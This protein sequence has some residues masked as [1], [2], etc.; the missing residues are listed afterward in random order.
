[1]PHRRTPFNAACFTGCL[2]FRPQRMT[3]SPIL[4]PTKSSGRKLA[5]LPRSPPRKGSNPWKTLLWPDWSYPLGEKKQKMVGPEVHIRRLSTHRV[6]QALSSSCAAQK[7]K[8]EPTWLW[9]RIQLI[10]GP[11]MGREPS[12]P[13]MGLCCWTAP[14]LLWKTC[15]QR[16]PFSEEQHMVANYPYFNIQ[17]LLLFFAKV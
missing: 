4:G 10:D 12:S 14:L 2:S 3:P 1:M 13:S 16:N 9:N 8:S 7:V 6:K 17:C 11:G 15:R 5:N